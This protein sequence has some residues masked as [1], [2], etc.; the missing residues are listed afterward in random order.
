MTLQPRP[1]PP[2]SF[3]HPTEADGRHRPR[4]RPSSPSPLAF[5]WAALLS[6]APALTSLCVPEALLAALVA[7][8]EGK[9]ASLGCPLQEWGLSPL[10]SGA[11]EDAAPTESGCR[12]RRGCRRA[13]GVD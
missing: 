11:D 5:G 4:C 1:Q 10:G 8:Q 13:S 3:R 7:S 12:P 9:F 6:T 2:A